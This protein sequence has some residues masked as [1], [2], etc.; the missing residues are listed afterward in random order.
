[1]RSYRLGAAL[2]LTLAAC[3]FD[4]RRSPVCGFELLA[5]PRLIQDRLNDARAL[6]TDAPRGL[7]DVLPARVAGRADTAHAIRGTAQGQLA[8]VYEGAYFPPG[9]SDST[10]YGLLVVDDSSERVIGL[11]VYEGLSPPKQYPRIGVVAHDAV[12]VPLFGVRVNW[13]SIYNPRCPL[14]GSAPS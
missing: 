11:L 12:T 5:G 13:A 4:P 6:L 8:L 10:V 3:S 7:P 9:I 14:L 2:A 1:M